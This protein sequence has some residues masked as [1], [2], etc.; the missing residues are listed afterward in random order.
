MRTVV[1]GIGN[2]WASDDRVGVEIVRRLQAISPPPAVP[3][4]GEA[5]LG[6]TK[7]LSYVIVEQATI[8]LLDIMTVCDR[9][10]IVD[11]VISGAPP[12]TIHQVTWQPNK[13]ASPDMARTSSHGFGI[14]QVL[15]LASVLKRLPPQVLLWGVEVASTK[16][17]LRL[18][19]DVAAAV[20]T[21]V[22][23]IKAMLAK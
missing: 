15:E 1:V 20:P 7:R 17:G 5:A 4:N 18:S 21:I 2:S 6:Q 9:L 10:I 3:D 12:G 16:P 23:Q 14:H 13:L 8:D 22:A 19:P 11:A